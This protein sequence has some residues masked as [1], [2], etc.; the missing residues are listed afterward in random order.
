MDFSSYI[1]YADLHSAQPTQ[2]HMATL[3]VINDNDDNE[4]LIGV[5]RN[6]V[7]GTLCII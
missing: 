3:S 7:A 5:Q 2:Q 6:C 4:L 1:C